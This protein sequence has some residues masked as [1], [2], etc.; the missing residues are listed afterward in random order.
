MRKFAHEL[1]TLKPDC[2]LGH[3][4]PVVTE[5]M[6]VTKSIPTVFVMISDPIASG[7][8][9][10]M[11]R[12]GG[13]M[14]GFTILQPTITGKYLELLREMM[15]R[16][17]RAAIM[18]NPQSVPA[19]GAFF[20]R[21]F[22]ESASAFKVKPIVAEVH[23]PA[24][25]ERTITEL[26]THSGSCL[27]TVPDNFLTTHR[28]LVIALTE[29]FS[30][31]AVYPYRYFAEAGGLQSYGVDSVNMFLRATDYVSRVLRGARPADLPVQAPIKFELVINMRTARRLG[32]VVP[33]VLLA[34]ADGLIE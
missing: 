8:V 32:L 33:R 3:S 18:Y 19:A 21:P 6:K 9:T 29:K 27:L 1:V 30:I 5:L 2:I 16:L 23:S 7:F 11:A 15:P 12:P 28:H 14:T 20:V 13:N 25:I 24:E 22:M 26:G 34:G 4:T 31:P 10:S 17:S